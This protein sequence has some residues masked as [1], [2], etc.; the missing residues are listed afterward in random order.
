MVGSAHEDGSVFLWDCKRQQQ[1]Y[2]QTQAHTQMCS[3]VTF[4]PVNHLLMC[5]VG[6]DNKIQFYDINDK[7][8]VKNLNCD[9]PI[10]S[11]AFNADGHTVA[12]G[13]LMGTIMIYDLR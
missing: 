9:V 2:K 5:S 11:I 1:M 12:A 8:I 6:L 7:K 13:T 10:S 4:S 3:G